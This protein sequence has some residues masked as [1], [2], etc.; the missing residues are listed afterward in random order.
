MLAPPFAIWFGAGRCQLWRLRSAAAEDYQA[1]RDQYRALARKISSLPKD[2]LGD[3]RRCSVSDSLDPGTIQ[4]GADVS[5]IIS[6]RGGDRK[7]FDYYHDDSGRL[8]VRFLHRHA[9][10]FL[11]S[12]WLLY[13]DWPDGFDPETFGLRYSPSDRLDPNW[14]VVETR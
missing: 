4:E 7:Y 12:F 9:G 5:S 8:I 14:W 10:G 3:P 1:R 6:G 13:T 11:G 2:Q